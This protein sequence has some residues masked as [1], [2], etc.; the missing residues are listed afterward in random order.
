MKQITRIGS[1]YNP[2]ETIFWKRSGSNPPPGALF[3]YNYSTPVNAT[4]PLAGEAI[5]G[6]NVINK[7]NFSKT[8]ALG[9]DATAVLESLTTGM[10]LWMGSLTYTIIAPAQIFGSYV[11]ITISPTTQKPDGNYQVV[12]IWGATPPTTGI[13]TEDGSFFLTEAGDYLVQE[14]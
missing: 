12:F 5:H 8:D 2:G 13:L 7:I 10:A 9:A 14:A 3:N 1:V 6:D 11:S 4:V